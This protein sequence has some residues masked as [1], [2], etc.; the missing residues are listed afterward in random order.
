[1]LLHVMK[2]EP[3]ISFCLHKTMIRERKMRRVEHTTRMSE[4]H[5]KCNMGI[6]REECLPSNLRICEVNLN[7][8]LREKELNQ[9]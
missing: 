7:I 6:Q 9:G 5:T 2:E 4:I 1:M 8:Y 3:R